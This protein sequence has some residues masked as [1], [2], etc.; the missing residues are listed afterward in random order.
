MVGDSPGVALVGPCVETGFAQQF[1]IQR[2]VLTD[3][4]GSAQYLSDVIPLAIPP[5]LPGTQLAEV[6]RLGRCTAAGVQY[7]RYE[8]E[9][10]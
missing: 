1:A 4:S 7:E 5:L 2:A 10:K 3:S 8:G 6:Q 9:L